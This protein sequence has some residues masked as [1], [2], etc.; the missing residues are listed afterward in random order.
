LE[1][2]NNSRGLSSAVIRGIELVNSDII[3]VMDA[4]L[5]HPPYLLKEM[6]LEIINGADICIPSRFIKGGSDGGLNWYRKLVS[7]T[8][9]TIGKIYLNNLKYISDITSGIFCFRKS[10]LLKDK[11][12]NPIGWKIMLE[13]LTKSKYKIVVEIPYCFNKR[14]ACQTKLNN[15]VMLDYLKQLPILKKEQ[16]KNVYKVI[17]REK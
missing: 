15:K 14:Y 9:R 2:R 13:V 3:A 12:L 6:Y 10:N 1:H 8:A 7:Y 11:K 16:V 4:D 17:R 5:Q